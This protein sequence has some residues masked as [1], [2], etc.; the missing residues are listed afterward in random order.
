MCAIGCL[1]ALAAAI[2]IVVYH[3]NWLENTLGKCQSAVDNANTAG[4]SS[5]DRPGGGSIEPS[6]RDVNTERQQAAQD[7][8]KQESEVSRVRTPP[9]ALKRL[10]DLY[11]QEF[12]DKPQQ[13]EQPKPPDQPKSPDTLGE[14]SPTVTESL[15]VTRTTR[16]TDTKEPLTM[17]TEK[18]NFE[19]A[20]N[21]P[22]EEQYISLDSA[23]FIEV[24]ETTSN[25]YTDTQTNNLSVKE[26]V[27]E[28]QSMS[29]VLTLL[30]EI[31]TNMSEKKAKD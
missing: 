8:E 11:K 24:H 6:D 22:E 18:S 25:V 30:E 9:S 13:L 14:Q 15:E 31:L 12:T 2:L 16:V 27:K 4:N 28:K 26:F 1:L 29:K 7:P 20:G 5:T 17:V 3:T 21:H 19:R 23:N 10:D